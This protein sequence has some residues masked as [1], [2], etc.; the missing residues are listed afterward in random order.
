MEHLTDGASGRRRRRHQE[1]AVSAVAVEQQQQLIEHVLASAT[2]GE[3]IDRAVKM[4]TS[5]LARAYGG[6]T[7]DA[8]RYALRLAEEDVR[9]AA[10]I[11]AEDLSSSPFVDKKQSSVKSSSDSG[12]FLAAEIKNLLPRTASRQR[13]VVSAQA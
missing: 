8:L 9:I 10:E 5:R 1:E 7:K 4:D 13:S 12:N 11:R 6:K 3:A 2:A